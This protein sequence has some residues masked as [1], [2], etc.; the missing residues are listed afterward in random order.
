MDAPEPPSLV[1]KAMRHSATV[2]I[3]PARPR[4]RG[5]RGPRGLALALAALSL[6]ALAGLATAALPSAAWASDPPELAGRSI[7]DDVDALGS[8]EPEVQSA[9]DDLASQHGVD[10]IVVY[11]DRFT[12]AAD[13]EA[14]ADEVAVQ[15]QLGVDDVV[16]AVATK[17]R[18]YQLSVDPDFE[19]TDSQ[20]EEV[21]TE[22]IEPFLRDE[23][24]AGA[25]IG[26]ATGIGQVLAG[27]S[28]DPQPVQPSDSSPGTGFPAWLAWTI[29]IVIILVGIAVLVVVL[30]LRRRG[31]DRRVAAQAPSGPT[32]AELESAVGAA[33]I[34]LD[35]AVSSSDEELG[36]AVAQ[37]GEQAAA[38]F[39][40]ALAQVKDQLRQ[41]FEIKQ[42]LDDAVPDTD[43]ERRSWSE[44]ILAICREA[45]ETLDAQEESFD[46]LRDLENDPEPAIQA[47]ETQ[48]TALSAGTASVAASVAELSGRYDAAALTTVAGSVQQAQSLRDYAEKQLA[49]ARAAISSGAAGKALAIRSAQQAITQIGQLAQGVEGLRAELDRAGAELTGTI[50]E[51]EG[52]VRE[53]E[54]L[55]TAPTTTSPDQLRSL[56]SALSVEIERA[57]GLGPRNPVAARQ[58][59]GLAGA[60]LDAALASAR[61]AEEQVA[62]TLA[63]R[64]RAIASAQSDV[65]SASS[66][67][68]TRRGAVGTDARTRLSEAQRHLDQA[69]ALSSTDPA[70]SLREATTASQ[71]ANLATRSAQQ[72]LAAA[73]QAYY[74][75]APVSGG[76]D[77]FGGAFLGGLLGSMFG[78]GGGSSY[79]TGWSSGR[80]RGGFGGFGGSFGGFGGSSGR[81]S[82]GGGRR[83]GGGSFGGRSGGGSRG[84]RRGGGGRF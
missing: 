49:V 41:A 12:G 45:S 39:S 76:G 70:E 16:L 35:D 75:N 65:A 4:R 23:D 26:A 42:R 38:P 5:R 47:A 69:I 31:L 8:R 73:Q 29:A 11:T 81:S 57:R 15:N 83:G 80:S 59:L 36:F 82:F 50:A 66:F 52:D 3:A 24:W 68:Q 2:T 13:R 27:G 40:A 71:L 33:L 32:L 53:A 58:A 43:E 60:A 77:D 28:V 37:F 20:L 25:A 14:W 61:D 22:A 1:S 51:A 56:A 54:R 46:A 18:L 78:G 21:E 48:L 19:L 7:V 30:V 72:D 84:G 74:Q 79:R 62:R 17:D 63:Q 44:Q 55:A 67:L 34:D 6:A 9:L 64:D 10:L